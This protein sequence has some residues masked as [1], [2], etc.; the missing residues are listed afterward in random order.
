MARIGSAKNS[1]YIIKDLVLP[2]LPEQAKNK[3]ESEAYAVFL[4]YILELNFKR[5]VNKTVKLIFQVINLP[6]QQN[7][8][9]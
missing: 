8:H 2:D 7:Q 5:I 1:G 4:I 6:L 3:S 9:L